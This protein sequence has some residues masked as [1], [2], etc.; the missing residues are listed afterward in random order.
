VCGGGRERERERESTSKR[1]SDTRG[2]NSRGKRQRAA[3]SEMQATQSL[4]PLTLVAEDRI[5]QQLTLLNNTTNT[6]L[7]NTTHTRAM[8]DLTIKNRHFPRS[9]CDDVVEEVV[10]PSGG[11]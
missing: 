9:N 5:D 1:S 8:H 11:F 3:G 2:G 10:G 4:R 7:N 6:L